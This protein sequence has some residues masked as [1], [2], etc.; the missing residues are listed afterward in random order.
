MRIQVAAGIG[1]GPTT[2]A[3]FD[4]ALLQAGAANF[5]LITLSSVIPL[6]SEVVSLE[7]GALPDGKW[8][9]RLYV[10]MAE[11]REE[12][13]GHEAWAAIGWVRDAATGCGLMVE[14]YGESRTY[15]ERA[16]EA[17]LDAMTAERALDLGPAQIRIAGTRCDGTPCC[18][19]VVAVFCSIAW[20]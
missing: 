19:L 4:S 10:V 9:D 11:Q 2:L 20:S 13:I 12:R 15:V 18:A 6:G 8:G 5:N 17:S 14:H 1:R 3:A 7:A 16:V